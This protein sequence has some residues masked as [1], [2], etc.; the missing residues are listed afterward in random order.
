MRDQITRDVENGSTIDV[1]GKRRPGSPI[2]STLLDLGQVHHLVVE[3]VEDI[4][5]DCAGSS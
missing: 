1:L 2:A 3:V 4:D 5:Y